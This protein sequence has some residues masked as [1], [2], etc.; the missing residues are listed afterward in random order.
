MTDC[1]C[2]WHA[3]VEDCPHEPDT[4]DLFKYLRE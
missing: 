3:R 1:W 4:P 2:G